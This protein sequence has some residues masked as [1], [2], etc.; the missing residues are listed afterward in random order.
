MQSMKAVDYFL[1][2]AELAE[3]AGSRFD[4]AYDAGKCVRL[5]LRK[6]GNEFNVII[7]PGVRLHLS[8]HFRAP[9]EKPSSFVEAVRRE[10]DNAVLDATEQL[11][12]DRLVAFRFSAKAGRRDLLFEQFGKGNAMLLDENGKVIR[13]MRSIELGGRKLH[14]G[15]VYEPPAQGDGADKIAS[16][17]SEWA[18]KQPK[19]VVY[20]DANGGALS[21]AAEPSAKA[22]ASG[23]PKHFTTFSEA[24]DSYYKDFVE[25]KKAPSGDAGK[26][27]AKLRHSLE[28]QKKRLVELG[29]EEAS[30]RRAGELIFENFEKVEETLAKASGSKEKEI[31]LGV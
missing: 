6:Q 24:L 11:Q 20:Y 29:E 9:Q 7:E 23:A 25:P 16:A 3:A 10:L 14:A 28:E 4:N 2:V 15:A 31:E 18:V 30:A 5:R 12:A 8:R 21:F 19:P 1:A 27:V 17:V 13:Q 22:G 26:Q